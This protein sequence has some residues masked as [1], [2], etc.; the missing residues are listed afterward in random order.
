MDKDGWKILAIVFIIV[1]AVLLIV[2]IIETIAFAVLLN[3]G[4]DLEEKDNIC[5][6]EICS[7]DKYNSYYYDDYENICYCYKD[8][9]V[10]YQEIVELD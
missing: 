1:S 5:S 8:G 7:L 4:L 10:V 2:I 3:Y 6:V 9:E